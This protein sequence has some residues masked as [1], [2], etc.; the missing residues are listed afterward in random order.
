MLNS[1]RRIHA[2]CR[3]EFFASLASPSAWV[4]LVIFVIMAGVCTFVFSDVLAVG[5]ADLSP[6][7][8]W[9]P[10][11]FMFLM[12]AL[13]MPM[14]SEERRTGTFDLS[15][16][17]PIHLWELVFGKYCAGMALLILALAL[18]LPVPITFFVLGEPDTGAIICGYLGAI[19]VGSGFLAVSCFC[20]ALSK[21]Q[22]ASFLLALLLCAILMFTGWDRVT[23]LLYQ[24]LPETLCRMISYCTVVPHY[25]AFQRGLFDTSEIAYSILITMLFLFFARTSLAFSASNGG[26]LLLPGAWR[27][28]YLW[29][30]TLCAVFAYGVAAYVF[31]C[32]ALTA[33][34]FR[35]RIDCTADRAYSLSAEAK[36]AAASLT[37]PVTVRLYV[38]KTTVDTPKDLQSYSERIKWLLREF[39]KASGGKIITDFIPVEPDSREEEAAIVEGIE[40]ARNSGGEKYFLGLSVSAGQHC[41]PLPFLSPKNENMLE[42]EILRRIMTVQNPKR[43]V[44][45]VMSLFPVLGREPSPQTGKSGASAWYIFTELN[46]DY[47]LAEVP[48]EIKEIPESLDVLMLIHPFGIGQETLSAIDRYLV[49]GGHLAVFVDPMSSYA[50]AQARSQ[51]D[52]TMIDKLE[53]SL[54]PLISAWG[55]QYASDKLAADMNFKFDQ[56]D[57]NGIRRTIPTAL[58]I[59]A[60][61][62]NSVNPVTAGLTSLRMNYSGFFTKNPKSEVVLDAEPLITTTN[63]SAIADSSALP[64]ETIAAF[65]TKNAQD[66][67]KLPLMWH[68]RGHF[69]SAFDHVAKED[70][71]PGEVFL[72]GDSDMLFHD[73]CV[74]QSTD[75]FGQKIIVRKNDNITLIENVLET[76][77]G[78]G[79]LAGLRSRVP[80]SRPLTKINESRT[81]A[82]L[83]FKDRIL[84]IVEESTLLQK[85]VESIRRQLIASGGNAQL[86]SAQQ[87]LLSTYAQK[88]ASCKREIREL[89]L[90]LRQDID[91]INNTAR[92]INIVVVPAFVIL[93]GIL[94]G[95]LRKMKWRRHE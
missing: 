80:M 40:P 66:G 44:I 86:T 89:R 51:K 63:Y 68:L 41:L 42:Y 83:E 57:S 8:N 15:L 84:A 35:I 17:F 62:M 79:R 90:R 65:S 75:E 60:D 31:F 71:E 74:A 33:S 13:G 77:C 78:K 11:L 32:L 1:L 24:W 26:G 73:A 19:L 55:L 94:W 16:S 21:S 69:P 45:G 53:S 36:A 58:C 37:R 6:F 49:N 39:A 9:M 92:L 95:I 10:W 52:L 43:P 5:Q 46:K 4:F 30:Q 48:M 38:S 87:N 14:W 18:T 64:E 28:R 76:L 93:C 81:R 20:S 47:T 22:T 91:R 7:F 67:E 27:D 2:V 72:F 88:D 54:E 59:T 34:A 70:A 12:P 25:Q 85:Q 56:L 3:R 50:I 61:G 23:G 82:D 29:K